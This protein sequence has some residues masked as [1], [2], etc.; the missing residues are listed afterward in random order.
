MNNTFPSSNSEV[1]LHLEKAENYK[2]SGLENQVQLELEQAR[3]LDPYIVHEARYKAIIE[4]TIPKVQETQPSKTAFRI[5]AGILFINAALG[6]VFLII[7]LMSGNFTNMQF[8][9][10][11][12]PIIDVVIGVNLWQMNQGSQRRTIFWAVI[13]LVLFGGQALVSSDYFS[14]II[15]SAFD[16]SLILLLAGTPS[17]AR[18]IIAVVIFTIGYL[19]LIC[20][21]LTGIFLTSIGAI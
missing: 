20:L 5:G 12:Q 6:T 13:G 7:G 17:K 4:N 15:Q 2:R 16:G 8:D 21:G 18:T 11:V 19:G 10:F 1:L 9:S 14:L 3:Q